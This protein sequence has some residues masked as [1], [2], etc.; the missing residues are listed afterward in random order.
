MTVRRTFWDNNSAGMNKLESVIDSSV[1]WISRFG[2]DHIETRYVRKWSEQVKP[3]VG[4]Q[5]VGTA[6]SADMVVRTPADY[7]I[8]YLSSHNGCTMGCKFCHLTQQGQTSFDHVGIDGYIGQL[9]KVLTHYAM[10]L[11]CGD[12][13]ASRL[14]INYMARGEPFA[15][16]Y[17]VNNYPDLYDGILKRVQE[18]FPDLV[19]K[20]N[21]ST[22]MP[23]I[24][25][26][27]SLEDVFKGKPAHVYYSLYSLNPKFR[28]RWIPNAIPAVEALNKLKKYEDS[29]LSAGINSPVTFHWAIIKNHNDNI[30]DVKETARVLRE[31]RFRAKFNMVRYNPHPNSRSTESDKLDE[32]FNIISGALEHGVEEKRSYIVPRVGKD[33]YASCGLFTPTGK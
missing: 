23:H 25:R 1:N 15:N 13:P 4:K 20:H 7:F 5:L 14:N 29:A 11:K 32:I 6:T 2:S 30:E 9:D 26:Y 3:M 27:R 10:R 12:S 24:M 21:I 18:Q 8:A 16:K 22:I 28:E 33:V 31:Y 19:V 17:M